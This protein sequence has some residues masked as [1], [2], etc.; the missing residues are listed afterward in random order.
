MIHVPVQVEL[1]PN[2]VKNAMRDT[3]DTSITRR[4]RSVIYIPTKQE[5]M[6]TWRQTP[7]SISRHEVRAGAVAA[8][9]TVV[10]SVIYLISLWAIVS[11]AGVPFNVEVYML[12][13]TG[14]VFFALFVTPLVGFA[15]GT[16]V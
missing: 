6:N 7:S 4:E 8:A 11:T 5:C 9:A 16:A 15:V 12:G 13:Y 10:T 3:E 2:S 1:Y 14:F